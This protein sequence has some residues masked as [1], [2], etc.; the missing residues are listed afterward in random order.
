MSKKCLQWDI[1]PVPPI[2]NHLGPLP[3]YPVAPVPFLRNERNGTGNTQNTWET[4]SSVTAFPP[5]LHIE[6]ELYTKRTRDPRLAKQMNPL[7]RI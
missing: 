5:K 4:P 3:G 2:L 1:L 6:H 7:K